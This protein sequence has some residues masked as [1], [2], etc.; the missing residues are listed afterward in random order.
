MDRHYEPKRLVSCKY[1]EHFIDISFSRAYSHNRAR[2]A[3]YLGLFLFC[4]IPQSFK[5]CF[6]GKKKQIFSKNALFVLYF[7]EAKLSPA[8]WCWRLRFEDTMKYFV[9]TSRNNNKMSHC[10][11]KSQQSV[12]FSWDS[13]WLLWNPKQSWHF[14][15]IFVFLPEKHSLK[16][17]G[18]TQNIESPK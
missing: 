15:K 18:I 11:L 12:P 9:K 10:V 2:I 4:V 17:Y 3:A 1:A 13:I 5:E 7:K 6:S 16:H 8:E 14:L